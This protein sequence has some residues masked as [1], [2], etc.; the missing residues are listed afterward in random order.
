M[1]LRYNRFT[2]LSCHSPQPLTVARTSF[3]FVACLVARDTA[4]AASLPF[5]AGFTASCC[6]LSKCSARA[7]WIDRHGT[8][9]AKHQR[10]CNE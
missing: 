1:V 2:T 10:S 9:G 4:I 5:I 7:A 8:K 6:R 3:A